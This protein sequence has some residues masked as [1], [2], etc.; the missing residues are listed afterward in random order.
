MARSTSREKLGFYALPPQHHE[1][2]LSLVEVS[3]DPSARIIDPFAGEGDFLALAAERW[4]MTPY[5]NELDEERASKCIERFGAT[6]A[7][8]GDAL[9][10][11][12]S[13]EAFSALWINPP[14]DSAT[15]EG[16]DNRVELK[17]LRHSL[18]WAQLNSLVFWVVY[19]NHL[20]EKAASLFAKYFR[21]VDVWALEG[22]H[23]SKYQQ[24]LVVGIYGRNPNPD[25]AYEDILRQRDN[26]KL[27]TVQEQPL[28]TVP[29]V[30]EHQQ[31]RFTTHLMSPQQALALSKTH[32]ASH[33]QTLLQLFH[34]EVISTKRADPIVL[35]R[36]GHMALVLGSGITNGTILETASGKAAVRGKINVNTEL[37]RRDVEGNPDNP[38][39]QVVKTTYRLRPSSTIS[40]LG[41][42]GTITILEGDEA[43]LEFISK[44]QEGLAQYLNRSFNPL[45]KFDFRLSTHS[46]KSYLDAI[47]VK[48]QYSLYTAQKHIVAAVCRGFESRKGIL[49]NGM[50]G[51]GKTPIASTAIIALTGNISRQLQAQM[52][53][54]QVSLLIA[55][56]HL[57]EKWEREL[58]TMYPDVFVSH[59]KRHEEVKEFLDTIHD[60]TSP[61][62]PFIRS[63]FASR[64]NVEQLF[65]IELY[66]AACAV[67]PK[68]MLVKRDMAKLGSSTEAAVV[69]REDRIP[70]WKKDAPV[71]KGHEAKDR[72]W[73]I[74]TPTCPHC[75]SAV[76]M[77]SGKKGEVQV[78]SDDWL[79]KTRRQ[80]DNC[81]QPLWQSKRLKWEAP[82][83][84]EKY[85]PCNPRYPIDE[86]LARKYADR[87]YLLIWDEAHEAQRADRGNGSAFGRIANIAKKILAMT[88]TPFNGKS[89]SLFNLEFHLNPEV[90]K[91]YPWGGS[92]RLTRKNRGR[93]FQGF[94]AVDDD[95]RSNSEARWVRDMGIM[96]KHI[97]E[98]P[99][100]D[101]D[102]GAYTGVATYERPYV[103]ANGISP[104]LVAEMLDH[105]IYLGLADLG[106]NLPEYN[107]FTIPV[108]MDSDIKE[109]YNKVETKLKDYLR[110][111]YWDGDTSFRG[112]YF[113]W[114][115]GWPNRPFQA[116]NVIH[117]IRS[118]V[119]RKQRFPK[120]IAEIDAFDPNRIFAKEQE[121][122][123]LLNDELADD[124]PCVIYVR[125][126]DTNDIQP[127]LEA[128]LRKH[129]PKAKFYTLR[130][131]VAAEK[132]EKVIAQQVEKGINVLITN[133]ILVATGLDL[134]HFKTLVWYEPIYDLRIM[135]QASSRT[136]RAN[137]G[138]DIPLKTIYMFYLGSMEQR[139]VELMSRKQRAAKLLTGEVGL[140]GLD[141]LTENESNFEEALVNTML[142]GKEKLTDLRELF[143]KEDRSDAIS[144]ADL[145]YWNREEEAAEAVV[146]ISPWDI[147][148][149][150]KKSK[151]ILNPNYLSSIFEQRSSLTAVN[152]N[153]SATN[154]TDAIFQP[155]RANL[156]EK[157][158]AAQTLPKRPVLSSATST[159][160]NSPAND[161]LPLFAENASSNGTAQKA[162]IG[163]ISNKSATKGQVKTATSTTGQ[164]N[165]KQ[166]GKTAKSASAAKPAIIDSGTTGKVKSEEK[167][168]VEAEPM[169]LSKLKPM[170]EIPR[171]EPLFSAEQKARIAA[172]NEPKPKAEGNRQETLAETAV[173]NPEILLSWLKRNDLAVAQV[174]QSKI[175][176]Q[177]PSREA[178]REKRLKTKFLAWQV[179]QE[180][181]LG[182]ISKKPVFT[183]AEKQSSNTPK[184]TAAMLKWQERMEASLS[185]VPKDIITPAEET[186]LSDT[187]LS[188]IVDHIRTKLE[189]TN[190]FIVNASHHA[191]QLTNLILI[192]VPDPNDS[193]IRIASGIMEAHFDTKKTASK[194][195]K[196]AVKQYL[197][198]K[199]IIIDDE[200]AGKLSI[201][202]VEAAI[203][204]RNLFAKPGKITRLELKQSPIKEKRRASG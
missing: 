128:L 177:V 193:S 143:K 96:E 108:S 141:S 107:E 74:K 88:G 183:K 123:N 175:F 75:G 87:I 58:Q 182:R 48:G 144:Q 9:T 60:A 78:A 157:L 11:E 102:T 198:K 168:K 203:T 125:Q 21:K 68:I 63:L 91:K 174:P 45:Y 12:A 200:L 201:G 57:I 84:G 166:E 148:R 77:S 54:N 55:P 129:V 104:R 83:E 124:R 204:A 20:T 138:A 1:A 59:C 44:N 27:L 79:G 46:L 37:A 80:C 95:D 35:P 93:G 156:P 62:S 155:Q 121:L 40:L 179:R 43:L 116:T 196:S 71:P 146:L 145:A 180:A 86:Y 81:H 140:T 169:K 191:S 8:F 160:T 185:I 105:T 202:L 113:Q 154:L 118:L 199:R 66:I 42:D 178:E 69:W 89:S 195:L 137:S 158:V 41:Q 132:R 73:K 34:R 173:F 32:G 136:L 24:I 72:I 31:F 184:P 103:E 161:V 99:Q 90:R 115:L 159:K 50:M 176:Q 110:E 119:N 29:P 112:A 6:N 7:V 85:A 162:V 47:K 25:P 117:N 33:N 192:G 76:Y 127:R 67:T 39:E 197:R 94:K 61:V 18:K 97:D 187:A 5:A 64:L 22:K 153:S 16:D 142:T 186:P 3:K 170:G 53:P 171:L 130:A 189:A 65:E 167:T 134:I 14:Y 165:S 26:P 114:A 106:A 17:L 122:I 100:Y 181:S 101:S 52:K 28:Y 120:S 15:G 30:S 147:V 188:H 190:P 151:G 194:K 82:E 172:T 98:Y 38:K 135:S 23:L 149:E 70:Q 150:Y 163:T 36:P 92:P 13:N 10:L 131:S 126:T 4:K 164:G 152:V 49:L 51:V 2:I 133:P 56:P 139:A 111:R 19:Q 109:T